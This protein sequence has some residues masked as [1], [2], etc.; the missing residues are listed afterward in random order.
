MP[1]DEVVRRKIPYAICTD[2]GASPT[3]SLLAEMAEFLKVHA[4]RSRH[5]TPQ[6]AL[7]RVTLGAARMLDVAD[8]VGSLAVGRPMSF[9]EIAA[10]N[11][12][13]GSVDDVILR[14]LLDMTPADLASYANRRDYNAAFAEL[15]AKGVDAGDALTLLT[16]DIA[17]TARRLDAKVCRVTLAGE[18]VWQRA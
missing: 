10:D 8:E 15:A 7:F 13:S 12:L 14:H 11:D 1:L 18:T 9:V 2:V 16:M 4:G 5:A 6:E 3:T 17:Q